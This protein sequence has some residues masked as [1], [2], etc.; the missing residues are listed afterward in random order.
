MC[1]GQKQRLNHT[2]RNCGGY[3][4]VVATK[5][6]ILYE[7]SNTGLPRAISNGDNFQATANH[8]SIGDKATIIH[9]VDKDGKYVT[10]LTMTDKNVDTSGRGLNIDLGL[11]SQGKKPTPAQQDLLSLAAHPEKFDV[12]LID[13]LTVKTSPYVTGAE[14][15]DY[16]LALSVIQSMARG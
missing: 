10:I 13:K 9:G 3:Y 14:N 7:G 12:N 11:I 4:D 15:M 2:L 1:L 6:G 5:E 8:T 16:D